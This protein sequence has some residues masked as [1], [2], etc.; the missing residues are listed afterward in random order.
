MIPDTPMDFIELQ[1]AITLVAVLTALLVGALILVIINSY[2]EQR[3][4]RWR[5]ALAELS[6][7]KLRELLIEAHAEL[8]GPLAHEPNSTRGR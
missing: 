4:L 1:K 3:D 2:A 7:K 6:N 8:A 5:L